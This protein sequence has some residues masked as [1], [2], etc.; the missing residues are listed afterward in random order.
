M[1]GMTWK[2][3]SELSLSVVLPKMALPIF[4]T[5]I[6]ISILRFILLKFDYVNKCFSDTT[7]KINIILNYIST[8]KNQTIIILCIILTVLTLFNFKIKFN[9]SNMITIFIFMF[10]L[11]KLF[12]QLF[13]NI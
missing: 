8:D 10:G 1:N 5:F 9:I 4:Y 12:L 7:N 3:L 6:L 11:L 2:D 13:F